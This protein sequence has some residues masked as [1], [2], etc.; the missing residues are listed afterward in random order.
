MQVIKDLAVKHNIETPT[1]DKVLMWRKKFY[2][3]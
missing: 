3:I 1:I 2:K